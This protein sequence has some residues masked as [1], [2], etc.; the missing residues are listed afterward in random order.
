MILEE[1]VS[2][3]LFVGVDGGGTRTRLVLMSAAGELLGYKEG[4]ASSYLEN[5]REMVAKSLERL[6]EPFRKILERAESIASCFGLPNVGEFERSEQILRELVQHVTCIRPTLIVND[7]VVG[8]AGGT[9]CND[10]VHVVAGTGSI[11]YGRKDEKEVRIG[12]WGSIIGDEGSAY[13][14][15]RET[16]RRVTRQLDGRDEPTLLKDIVMSSM[17]FSNWYDVIQWIYEGDKRSKIASIALHTYNA[18]IRGDIVAKSILENAAIELAYSVLTAV[19]KLKL[20]EPLISYSG[21]V[22]E[23]NEIVKDKFAS[24]LKGSIPSAVI[25]KAPLAPVLGAVLLAYKN[26]YGKVDENFVNT[27]F[28]VQKQLFEEG[29]S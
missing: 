5:G 18:T 3:L 25:R 16:L 10:G 9:L 7:V 28:K 21:S 26:M 13:D 17:D 14:I 8:W 20:E 6:F 29:R 15:G 4:E 19:K 22:L 27:L 23:K 11:V 1:K 2:S 24:C 12:G